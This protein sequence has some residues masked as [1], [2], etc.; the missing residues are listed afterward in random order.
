M[1]Q[2]KKEQ[3]HV[4]LAVTFGNILEWFEI[5]S[6]AY[7]VPILALV[8]F[9][10]ESSLA[11]WTSA[12]IVFG[13][14][15]LT[16]PIG[17]IIFGRIGDL[18]GRK[19]AFILSIIIMTVPTFLMGC[20]PTYTQVGIFAPFLLVFLRLLQSIPAAGEAPGTFCFLYENADVTNRKFMGSWGAFG[21]QIGAI[22][23]VTQ[24]FF[25]EQFMSYEFLMSWGWR[26]SFWSGGLIGLFGIYLRQ[27]LHET[28]LFIK[29]KEH[30]KLDKETVVE[31]INN[32]KKTIGIGIAFSVLNCDEKG[33][34]AS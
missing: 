24:T 26:I 7:L 11:N 4:I 3:I 22:L 14:G 23:G 12:F 21:N 18:I 16:R 20:L 31:V 30:H 2:L 1:F 8:F 6:Y 13:S 33:I 29:L 15:F 10:F 34:V 32:H 19:R 17:A 27:T 5:Y 28:P 9:N 25:M